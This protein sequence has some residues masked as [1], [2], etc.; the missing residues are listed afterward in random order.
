MSNIA[1]RL[2]PFLSENRMS[3]ACDLWQELGGLLV[4]VADDAMKANALKFEASVAL[5]SPPNYH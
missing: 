1:A 2:G 3:L 5:S 4:R